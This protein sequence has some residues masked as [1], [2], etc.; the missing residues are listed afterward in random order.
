[1]E[2]HTRRAPEANEIAAQEGKK[3]KM[4]HFHNSNMWK[5][6]SYENTCFWHTKILYK[7]ILCGCV[8]KLTH[9][10]VVQTT[11]PTPQLREQ[12]RLRQRSPS[13]CCLCTSP[14][15]T[16][17]DHLH[18]P[19]LEAQRAMSAK[20]PW[21]EVKSNRKTSS[22]LVLLTYDKAHPGCITE[23]EAFLQDILAIVH[24]DT[25]QGDQNA[26]E[27]HLDVSHPQRRVRAL[28]HLL[29]VHTLIRK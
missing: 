28:Q 29:E 5:G 8:E 11:W 19:R 9:L 27:V 6:Y 16:C 4:R 22:G 17:T 15:P 12:W 26:R 23:E 13:W 14:P 18:W 2:T 10:S 7:L 21:R 20:I 1:M 3:S 24:V 25:D